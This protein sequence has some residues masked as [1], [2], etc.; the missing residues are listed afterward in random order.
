MNVSKPTREGVIVKFRVELGADE[1]TPH[2]EKAYRKAQ[3]TAQIDGFRKGKVPMTVIQ[4]KF[5]P[6][7]K[8]DAAEE[9][10][11]SVFPEALDQ[12]G[13]K[14]LAPASVEDVDYDP[15][16][17][18]NFTAVV[19]VEPEIEEA[20]WKGVT[21]EKEVA[22]IT[23]EDIDLHLKGLQ[24]EQAIISERPE[25]EGAEMGDRLAADI[26]QLDEAGL[27]MIGKRYE[28][29]TF[30][31]GHDVLGHGSDEF[32]VGLTVGEDRKIKTHQHVHNEKGEEAT[33]DVFWQVT[34]K[35]I[36][37]IELPELDDEFAS[38]VDQKHESMKDLRKEVKEQLENY[39]NYRADQRL[40]GKLVEAIVDQNEFDVP[41]SL[42]QD[43][44]ERLFQDQGEELKQSMD[45]EVLRDQLKPYAERQLRWYFLRHKLIGELKLEVSDEEIEKQVEEYAER[46][47]DQNLKDL[48]VMFASKENR[49]RLGDE[50]ISR[51]LLDALK[52]GVKFKE[53]KVGFGDLL[54]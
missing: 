22:K 8:A 49:Q 45:E 2:L 40:E 38:A 5:G 54:Q 53:K 18:L 19:E 35:K 24:R 9:I 51:K 30:E 29:Q 37:K 21:V 26:Q 15:E 16:D 44:V 32:L 4:Q 28:G 39:A 48:K 13:I 14:P 7:I 52:D 17:H 41:P 23:D 50:I 20:N 33:Q 25:G 3:K 36:E 1:I 31:I 42:V 27:P 34:A 46:S 12:T 43:T 10:V 11:Q 6:S 47:P